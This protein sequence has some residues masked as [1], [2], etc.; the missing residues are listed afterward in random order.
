MIVDWLKSRTNFTPDKRAIIDSE[1][2]QEWTYSQLNDRAEK[3]AAFFTEQ[4]IAKGDRVA[5]LAENNI[6]H[7]DFLF[8]S[9]KTG[10][11]FV[12]LNYRLTYEELKGVLDDCAPEIVLYSEKY[13]D[14][15]ERYPK[16]FQT[17]KLE[18]DYDE[19]FRL[20]YDVELPPPVTDEE[21]IAVLLYTSGTTGK[22]KGVMISHRGLINNAFY[23]IP[24]WNLTAEDRTITISP[25]YHTAGLNAL[26]IP[27]LIIGGEIV[28]QS[29]FDGVETFETIKKYRPTKIFMVPTMYYDILLHEELD[30]K[31]LSM[32]DLFVSGGAPMSDNVYEAFEN[33]ELPLIDSYGLSEAGSNNFYI[34]PHK[35]E[36]KKGTVGKPIMFNEVQIVDEY[37]E[38][39]DVNEVGEL[40][41]AGGHTFNG[42]FNAEEETEKTFEG[43]FVRTGD[44]ASFDEDGD[45]FIVGRKKELIISGGE[46]IIPVEVERV[47]NSHPAIVDSVVV[48]YPTEKWGESVGAVVRLKEGTLD[49]KMKQDIEDYSKKRLA[50]YKK[51]KHIIAV[52]EYPRNSVGKT[53]KQKLKKMLLNSLEDVSV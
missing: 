10:A 29:K 1:T 2:G 46:N 42:Y 14:V 47:L 43:R 36:E 7:F 24:T 27:L 21:E 28:I 26:V 8:A 34:P 6:S 3:L 37:N 32:V 48:G 50:V 9:I 13:E 17:F 45:Y 39:V 40:L 30:I 15:I 5:V 44:L 35:A 38:P 25:M 33:A 51:P 4:G 22:P 41:L 12:P 20:S 19:I 16:Q 11:V 23:T 49:A 52:D 53:D 31:E 18:E